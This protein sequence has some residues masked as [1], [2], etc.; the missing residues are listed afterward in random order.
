MSSMPRITSIA[1]VPRKPGRYAIEVDGAAFATVSAEVI[2]AEK[3]AP[4]VGVDEALAARLQDAGADVATYDRAL[5][6]LAV[7][8]RSARELRRRLAETEENA[9]RIERTI[10]RL[11]AVGLLDDA[12]Y[13]R[14]VARSKLLGQGASRRRLSQELFRRGVG[15]DVADEAI[16]EVMEEEAVDEE[17][18]VASVA[19]K[20]LRTLASEEPEVRRRRLYAFLARRG[21]GPD[22][23]RRALRAVLAESAAEFEDAEERIGERD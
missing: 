18:L 13:A 9:A 21:Y 16:G 10:E 7:R 12:R 11:T 17:A 2:G 6:L 4:G 23:I 15:R 20:K 22:V 3:L 19:R 5:R 14:Q 1:E 8:G